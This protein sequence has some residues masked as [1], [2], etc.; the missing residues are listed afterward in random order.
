MRKGDGEKYWER[1]R[2]T[3][4]SRSGRTKGGVGWMKVSAS[5]PQESSLSFDIG[6]SCKMNLAQ[7]SFFKCQIIIIIITIT[8]F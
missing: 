8:K 5:F 2:V 4:K 1:T 7:R 6:N 3:L